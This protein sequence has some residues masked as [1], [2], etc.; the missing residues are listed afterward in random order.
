METLSFNL[1]FN[2]LMV[3]IFS[4]LTGL[5]LREY[6][7]AKKHIPFSIGKTRTFTFIGILGYVLDSISL[8][9]FLV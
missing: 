9:S 1:L 2:F 4:F 8:N 6:L 7:F 3:I 5:E